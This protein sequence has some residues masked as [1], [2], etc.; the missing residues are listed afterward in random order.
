M[1][2]YHLD[3][4]VPVLDHR[5]EPEKLYPFALQ[6]W[7]EHRNKFCEK[8]DL[9]NFAASICMFG[10]GP[11]EGTM[12]VVGD[13][14]TDQDE[15]FGPY[16]IQSPQWAY[17]AQVA[18]YCD[19]NFRDV[20]KTY[21]VRCHVP[22]GDDRE[23]RI[24]AGV[25]ECQTYL[26]TELW[27]VKPK[28]ILTM[29]AGSYYA[30]TK[31]KGV[32]ARRGQAFEWE[33]PCICTLGRCCDGEGV[34]Q[35]IEPVEG[36]EPVTHHYPCGCGGIC[37]SKSNPF[38]TWVV[39]SISPAAVV[40][41]PNLHAAFE[42]DVAKWQRLA[43]GIDVT[44]DV[45][46]VQVKTVEGIYRMLDD[47]NSDRKRMLTFD[48]ETRG[49]QDHRATYSKVWCAALSNG[50]RTNNGIKVYSLPLEHPEA[51]WFDGMEYIDAHAT[52]YEVCRPAVEALTSLVLDPD[53]KL[54][55]HNAKF[56]LRNT[57]NLAIRYGI[58]NYIR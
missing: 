52:H 29:G 12:A 8:C 4:E 45:E 58:Q 50:T 40:A 48:L 15:Q 24:L 2:D 46:I 57:V 21:A 51:P 19:V 31:Q 37:T 38:K 11:R 26:W 42:S 33:I 1:N 28:A 16:S 47:L 10:N 6:Q 41:R 35:R 30:F 55:G 13:F 53:R 25:K 17:L 7:K 54:N 18:A 20:Y 9:H 23:K 27:E 44:P 43:S 56:D 5:P 34:I 22:R 14:P 3:Y 32:T 49:F 36:Q 39:P